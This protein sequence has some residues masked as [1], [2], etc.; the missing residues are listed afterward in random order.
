MP[1]DLLPTVPPLPDGQAA[2]SHEGLLSRNYA[3]LGD[4]YMR[5]WA[6]EDV[7]LDV[8]VAEADAELVLTTD[9]P[10]P[11][12]PADGRWRT[13]N[14]TRSGRHDHR[15]CLRPEHPGA[16]QFRVKYRL[17]GDPKWYWDRAGFTRLLV[18]PTWQRNLRVYTLVPTVSGHVGDWIEML[19]AIAAMGFNVIHLLPLSHMDYSA[20]PYC[21]LELC[22]LDPHYLD[23]TDP[24][25]GVEQFSDFADRAVDLGL[26]L[27]MDLVLNHVG[28]ASGIARHAPDWIQ[29]DPAEPDGFRRAG[30]SDGTHWHKWRDLCLLQFDHPD[31]ERRQALWDYM[32]GYA[33]FW[34]SF[35]HRTG[36]MVRLDNLHSGH[37]GLVG[38]VLSALREDFPDLG[39]LAELFT[40]PANMGRLVWEYRLGLLLATPWEHRFL[41]QLRSYLEFIHHQSPQVHFHFPI[42]SHD[43]GSPAEEFGHPD[44]TKPR[45]AVAALCS[46]GYTGMVQGV[47]YGVAH[48]LEFIGRHGRLE[49]AGDRDYSTFISRI[50]SLM[51][52]FPH[53][54]VGGNLRFVDHGHEAVLAAVR[55]PAAG[56][57]RYVLILAN[58]D[59]G[60]GHRLQLRRHDLAPDAGELR[61]RDLLTT[62]APPSGGEIIDITLQPCEVRVYSLEP[63]LP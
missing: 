43:S 37:E 40:D 2:I 48:K 45:Y 49:L 15:L 34:S 27:C 30:W 6:G 28:P 61:L 53:F 41:P 3:D 29:A 18:D 51:D 56:D 35:A 20:S 25:D 31:P 33:R 12:Q 38:A 19:P 21:A 26:R 13:L 14:F 22:A 58:F 52:R 9:M 11:G 8:V 54:Q 59:I 1:H 55:S 44:S 60:R 36:G 23:P 5:T 32:I 16:Y 7:P 10:A 4:R 17:P 24:R 62:A 46:C 63:E 42:S 39:I 50:N 57:S 47:E